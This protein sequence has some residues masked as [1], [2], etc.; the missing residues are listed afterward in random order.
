MSTAD[1]PFPL[2]L[3]RF[4]RNDLWPDLTVVRAADGRAWLAVAAMAAATDL[5]VR[6]GPG[7]SATL[8]VLVVA[9][10]LVASGRLENRAALGLAVAAPAFGT[11]L[12][13][14][15]SPPLVA[16][17]V[18]AAAGLIALAGSFARDG[19][20]L[21]ITLPD[22]VRRSLVALAHGVA[23]PE[24]LVRG[25]RAGG[26]RQLSG[27]RGLA[28]GR[29]LVLA[30][31]IV[32]V[33]G[34]LLADADPVFAS[35]FRIEDAGDLVA[36]AVLLGLGAWAGGGL[37][38]MASSAAPRPLPTVAWRLGFVETAC[39]LGGLVALYTAF[40]VAQLVAMAGG[41]SK[42]LDTAGLTY[43]EYARSGFAQLLVAATLTL[44]VLL[45]VRAVADAPTPGQR[46]TVVVL[47]EAAVVL[48]LAIVVV[49]VYRLHLYENAYGLTLAR[50]Y[51]TAFALWVGVVV[52]LLALS[53]AG[54]HARRRWLVAASLAAGLAGVLV[55]NVVNPE[56]LVVDR[57]IDHYEQTGKLDT[58]HLALLSDDA[59]P[60]I[61]AALPRLD[62][63]TRAAA[64][65]AVCGAAPSGGRDWLSASLSASRAADARAKVCGR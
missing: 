46:R 9:G 42:V 24:F 29:G 32:L 37:L 45:A 52:V 4:D 50:L 22:L 49:A 1:R 57:N 12:Y 30:V 5:V 65:D 51:A 13:L 60:A 39:V 27:D 48:T 20:P 61:V 25:G 62:P 21:D 26:R 11:C 35:W 44:G 53:L 64:V 38:R 54:L 23:A 6:R 17:N 43:A 3:D 63:V 7:L 59:V 55:L 36:H 47:A 41:A 14:H 56:R 15:L 34:F 28:V 10:G 19:D 31:P 2:D 16:L 40:A 18:L 33:L 58:A 8:F